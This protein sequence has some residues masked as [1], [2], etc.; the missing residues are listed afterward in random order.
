M[1]KLILALI[2]FSFL[3]GSAHALGIN[4]GVA[5]NTG[6]YAGEATEHDT[7]SSGNVEKATEDAIG[8]D[9]FASFFIEKTLGSRFAIGYEY[10]DDV[11][12]SDTAETVK[13][14]NLEGKDDNG[15]GGTDT[16]KVQVDFESMNTFYVTFNLNENVY[17]KAGVVE[18]DVITNET[19]GTG[20]QYGNTSLDGD[21]FG[22][23]YDRTFDNNF[24]IR[25]EGTYL[26]LGGTSV[27]A[28]NTTSGT[29]NKVV[30]EN[31]EGAQAKFAIGKSF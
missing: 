16:N 19:L 30:V 20:S 7:D 27:T 18:V 1:K 2:T 4:V 26:D 13:T 28:T 29:S 23:G 9:S 31:V 12:S 14:N 3:Y 6:V 10:A 24:F 25:V 11:L 17:V 21:T 22:I 15:V 5:T 8:V